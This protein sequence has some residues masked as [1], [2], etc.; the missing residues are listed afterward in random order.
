MGLEYF[1]WQKEA[2]DSLIKDTINIHD[3]RDEWLGE[4][5]YDLVNCTETG[6]HIDPAYCDVFIENL[7][8]FVGPTVNSYSDSSTIKSGEGD[9][10]NS[11][12]CPLNFSDR[13]NFRFFIMVN[14]F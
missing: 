7:K 10:T 13:D 8:I 2:A 14:F 1:S 3:L 6:E 5:K 12:T 9:R 4:K 11:G